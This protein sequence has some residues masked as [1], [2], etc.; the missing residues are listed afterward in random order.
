MNNIC[1]LNGEFV[2][3]ADAKVSVLDR[4]FIFGEGLYEVMTAVECNLLHYKNHSEW[5]QDIY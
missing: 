3:L 4:G 5:I 2:S 1:Y